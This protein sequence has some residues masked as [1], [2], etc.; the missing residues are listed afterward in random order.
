LIQCYFVGDYPTLEKDAN[1]DAENEDEKTPA[2]NARDDGIVRL[3]LEKS[4]NSNSRTLD[5]E[6]VHNVVW[7]RKICDT[8]FGER[9]QCECRDTM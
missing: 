4:A 8:T 9:R 2:I 6:S 3:L 7:K 5:N 1:I